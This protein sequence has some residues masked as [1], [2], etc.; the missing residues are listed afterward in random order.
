MFQVWVYSRVPEGYDRLLFSTPSRFLEWSLVGVW[1]RSEWY[2]HLRGYIERYHAGLVPEN[3]DTKQKVA[4]VHPLIP[5]R[6]GPGRKAI[7]VPEWRDLG[8]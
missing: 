6:Q 3:F 8:V 5:E 1:P 4:R 7:P 2:P